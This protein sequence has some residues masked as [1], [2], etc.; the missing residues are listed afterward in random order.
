ML[1]CPLEELAGIIGKHLSGVTQFQKFLGQPIIPGKYWL[2]I[3][4]PDGPPPEYER[5][6]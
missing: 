4:Y 3:D 2:D 5:S 6:G 1:N